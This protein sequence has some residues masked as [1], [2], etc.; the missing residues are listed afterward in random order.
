MKRRTL[1]SIFL[2]LF[3][4]QQNNIAQLVNESN[5]EDSEVYFTGYY[6]NP[7]GLSSFKDIALGKINDP[8][9]RM[10]INPALIPNLGDK[11]FSFYFD[12][13]GDRT[14]SEEY[15]YYPPVPL[16]F[17]SSYL[18]TPVYN[19]SI[20]RYEPQPLLSAGFIFNPSDFLNKNFYAAATYQIIRRDGSNYGSDYPVMYMNESVPAPGA[21]QTSIPVFP[22]YYGYYGSE[23]IFT[24]AHMFSLH[25]GYRLSDKFSLGVGANIVNY[26]KTNNQINSDDYGYF[27]EVPGY[28]SNNVREKISDYSHFDFNGG[29]NYSL[30][31]SSSI[32][33]KA[34]YLFG[35]ISQI[36]YNER[37]YDYSYYY[38][39]S[40]RDTNIGYSLIDQNWTRDGKSF[41]TGLNFDHKIDD[42]KGVTAYYIFTKSNIDLSSSSSIMD[43]SFYSYRWYDS[44]PDNEYEYF[45][46]SFLSEEKN[47]TGTKETIKHEVSV[48]FKWD[49]SPSASLITGIFYKNKN[50]KI[51]SKEPIELKMNSYYRERNYENADSENYFETYEKG[52]LTWNSEVSFWT[53]QVPVFFRVVFDEYLGMLIGI[54]KV[55]NTW[56]ISEDVTKF[57]DYRYKN[58]NGIIEEKR[59]QIEKFRQP[60]RKITDDDTK[61]VLGFEINFSESLRNRIMFEP[62]FDPELRIAQWWLSFSANL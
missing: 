40:E 49:F 51:N 54:N 3:I 12:L 6:L 14:P 62:E 43:T 38:N 2:F 55:L 15:N 13:R 53:M 23:D 25:S 58:E 21:G 37:I 16:M 41:Y 34:G 4:S 36:N 11:T 31:M 44:F 5:F 26:E 57:V 17:G 29:I 22:E 28:I 39:S 35:D 19:H 46:R 45:G 7:F 32:G 50:D 47:S 27:Q 8:Y 9:L 56:K 60:V 61:V 48:T 20:N 18:P 52:D 1:L 42:V 59:G 33:L 24:E 10:V 30:S